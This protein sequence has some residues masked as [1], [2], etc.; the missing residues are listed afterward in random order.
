VLS[1]VRKDH[2][3]TITLLGWHV[4]DFLES[5]GVIRLCAVCNGRYAG[6]NASA[7]AVFIGLALDLF[8]CYAEHKAKQYSQPH[9][10]PFEMSAEEAP[11]KIAFITGITGQVKL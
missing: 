9:F 10:F 3:F 7:P 11:R 4:S 2:I 1:N 6:T 8:E 5:R